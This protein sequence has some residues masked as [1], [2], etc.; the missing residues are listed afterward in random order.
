MEHSAQIWGTFLFKKKLFKIILIGPWKIDGRFKKARRKEYTG[1]NLTR[2]LNPIQ[3][4]YDFYV[5][6]LSIIVCL[7][8]ICVNLCDMK[9]TRI[10]SFNYYV[11]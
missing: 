1:Q 10:N 2:P 6:G 9:L 7:N 4:R 8:Q 5:F 11:N 3:T